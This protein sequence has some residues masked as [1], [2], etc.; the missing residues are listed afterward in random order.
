MSAYLLPQPQQFFDNNGD[1]LSGGKV[2]TCVPGASGY[3]RAYQKDTYTDATGLTTNPNP[4]I[5]DSFGRCNI[6]GD[7]T[8]YKLFIFNSSDVLIDA[9]DDLAPILGVDPTITI[10]P[11]DN[12]IT[13]AKLVDGSITYPK[14]APG[15]V[16]AAKIADASITNAKIADG[17]V[18][19]TKIADGT[20]WGAAKLAAG[21]VSWDRVYAA[22]WPC[23]SYYQ[24]WPSGTMEQCGSCSAIGSTNNDP[25]T[26]PFAF[27]TVPYIEL[28][29]VSGESSCPAVVVAGSI[30]TTGFRWCRCNGNAGHT[31]HWRAFGK[32][33]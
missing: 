33:K 20:I 9:I 19:N 24:K 25:I 17:A 1:P 4:V 16:T 23:D 18:T 8:N 26:F 5:L 22:E 30:S 27:T 3:T 32:Y 29:I 13:T 31:I 6:W 2:Y 7:G 21:S 15:A 12:S 14:L 28:T 10:V 11:T